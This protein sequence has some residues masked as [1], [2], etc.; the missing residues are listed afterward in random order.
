MNLKMF[1]LIKKIIRHKMRRIQAKMH[2]IGTS[3]IDK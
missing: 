1:C 2:K 3:V